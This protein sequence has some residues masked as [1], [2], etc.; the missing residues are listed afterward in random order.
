MVVLVYA[1]PIALCFISI[2]LIIEG[3]T[4]YHNRFKIF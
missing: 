2:P 1:V 4:N 3:G